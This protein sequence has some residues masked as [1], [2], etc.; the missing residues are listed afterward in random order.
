LP[1]PEK[2]MNETELDHY[3]PKLVPPEVLAYG[4]TLAQLGV[5]KAGKL[6]ALVLR[7]E[8]DKSNGKTFCPACPLP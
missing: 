2:A 1:R 3:T 4:S 5:G 6:G 7:L 8:Q